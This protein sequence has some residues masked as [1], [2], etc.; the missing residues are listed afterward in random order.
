MLHDTYAKTFFFFTIGILL[1]S[2]TNAQSGPTLRE[3]KAKVNEDEQVRAKLAALK[4]K[5]GE[6]ASKFP[7]PGFDDW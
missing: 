2:E 6:F 7:M 3:F 1:T 4:T 5:V